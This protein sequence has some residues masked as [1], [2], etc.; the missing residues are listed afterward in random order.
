MFSTRWRLFRLLGIPI[1]LDLTWLII[2]IL[3]TGTLMEL[4]KEQEP[5]LRL[6]ERVGMA[7]VT[8]LAFFACIVLH[9]LGHA[10]VARATGLPIRGITLFLFGGVAELGE[11]P[12]SAGGEFVMAI[13]GPIVSAILGGLFLVLALAGTAGGWPEPP[14]RVFNYLCWINWTVLV[15]NLVPAFPLDGGRVLRS[16]LWGITGRL[17]QATYWAT[18]CG[19][20]FGWLLILGGALE[21]I[22]LRDWGGIWLAIIGLFVN[23]AAKG[24]YQQV[25]V[26]QA[27]AGEPV[28]RFMNPQPITVPPETTLRQFVE[29]YV[30]RHHRKAFPVVADGKLDGYVSTQKLA[31]YPRDEWDVHTVGDV[32]EHDWKPLSI[33][34]DAD[35]LKALSKMQRTGLSRLLVVD[36]EQ[37]LGMVSLKDLLQFLHLKLELEGEE[38][39]TDQQPRPPLRDARRESETRSPNV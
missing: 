7:L 31:G 14:L 2:L 3:M 6:F 33:S 22:Y 37:L 13:A 5:G 4:F 8:A 34:P 17:R 23:N 24:S 39:D 35:A 16:I 28:R 25:L 36:G 9:E 29:D 19:R 27:L 30:Y 38:S 15:F 11:E 1:Y 26:R 10:V 12:R 18:L 32:M 20:T 21:V